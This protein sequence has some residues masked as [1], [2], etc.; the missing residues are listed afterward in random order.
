MPD[1]IMG[2]PAQTEVNY[3]DPIY[4]ANYDFA[5]QFFNQI[6]PQLMGGS[7]PTYQGNVDP[8]LSQ[9]MQTAIRMAQGYA[10]SPAPYSLGQAG[11]TLGAFMQPQMASAGWGT[12]QP[13]PSYMQGPSDPGGQSQG[14]YNPWANASQQQSYGYGAGGQSPN[15][16]F[17]QMPGAQ[18]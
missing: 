12:Q 6:M 8:G 4:P 14:S 2:T 16:G 10:Q 3:P 18:R 17:G 5:T 13:R 11:G 9:T 15:G 7:L 1:G